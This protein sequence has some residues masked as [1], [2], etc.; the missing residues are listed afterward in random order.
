MARDGTHDVWKSKRTHTTR[1]AWSIKHVLAWI[2]DFNS[3][4]PL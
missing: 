2:D 1:K 4:V 3:D